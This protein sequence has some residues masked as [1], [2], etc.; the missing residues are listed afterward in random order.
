MN[1]REW[2]YKFR[3][4]ATGQVMTTDW[5]PYDGVT[6]IHE[7]RRVAVDEQ[8]GRDVFEVRSQPVGGA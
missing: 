3:D 1:A 4:P 5:R 7:L 2:Q 6:S 8:Q